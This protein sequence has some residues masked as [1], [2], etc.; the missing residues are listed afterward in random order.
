[1]ET[2]SYKVKCL[3]KKSVGQP[4]ADDLGVLELC[5]VLQKEQRGQAQRLKYTCLSKHEA[6]SS[7]PSAARQAK[8]AEK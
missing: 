3:N 5:R 6:L 8:A 2:S 7:N 4:V 1:V